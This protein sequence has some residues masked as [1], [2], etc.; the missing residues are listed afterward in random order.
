MPESTNIILPKNMP[1]IRR[2]SVASKQISKWIKSL[3]TPFNGEQDDI[4][5]IKCERDDEEF[6]YYYVVAR[7]VKGVKRKR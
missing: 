5:L 2:I 4:R 6:S 3:E 7:D 1:L